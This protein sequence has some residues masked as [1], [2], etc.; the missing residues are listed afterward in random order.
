MKRSGF[1]VMMIVFGVI[2]VSYVWMRIDLLR[3]GLDIERLEAQKLAVERQQERLQ[4]ELSQ[5]TAP[6][7]IAREANL[8]LGLE[9]PRA[10]QIVMV[11]SETK[12]A[13]APKRG[14]RSMQLARSPEPEVQP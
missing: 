10:G 14:E 1:A 7:K 8:K 6:Q 3:L 12:M 9:I 4:F 5:L 2:A 13:G 11:A